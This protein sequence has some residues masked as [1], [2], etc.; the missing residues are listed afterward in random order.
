MNR[1]Q[2]A[3]IVT[4]R[5]SLRRAAEGLEDVDFETA[6]AMLDRVLAESCPHA[7][8]ETVNPPG[9]PETVVC[10]ACGVS[11]RAYP[12]RTQEDADAWHR[13]TGGQWG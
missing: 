5:E 7:M 9:D 8:S 2:R 6:A 12:F 13:L 3:D 10:S 1:E 11:W 4:A